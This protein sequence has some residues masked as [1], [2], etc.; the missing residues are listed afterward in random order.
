MGEDAVASIVKARQEGEFKDLY[1]FCNRVDT[2][3]VGKRA[4]EALVCAGCFDDM[5]LKLAPQFSH[6]R[7][8]VRGG[9][10]EQLP[11][12][13]EVA[14]QNRQNTIDGTL[15]LFAEVDDG[16]SVAPPLP[17]IVWGDQTRLRG[18]K[19][20]LGLYLTGHPLD[21]YRQEL[22]KFVNVTSLSDVSDTGAGKFVRVAGLIVDVAN[23]GNRIA[24]TLDDGTAR[25]EISCYTDK[26]TQ[27]KPVLE[28]SISLSDAL[29][30]KYERT[31]KT[32]KNF[33]PQ[34]LNVQTLGRVDKKDWENIHNLNG[35]III[36]RIS[37]RE[38]DGRLFCR[39]HGAYTLPQ[40]RLRHLSGVNLKLAS[41]DLATLS[42]LI[43]L[44]KENAPPSAQDIP[45]S[46]DDS[47][48]SDGCLPI[49]LYIYDDCGLCK[50]M[51]NE[52][53]RFY[54]SDEAMDKLGQLFEP[55][56]FKVY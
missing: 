38:N 19:D 51:V 56:A 35:A 16:L 2:K 37:V 43:P 11:S 6:Q 33:N 25:L 48:Q 45:P 39:L 4:L 27:L 24:I 12:A 29:M 8:H 54:P 53:F 41:D 21:K 23:F 10:W 26:Y 1:D 32:E 31:I 34:K 42:Q 47:P 17:N 5:A 7:H 40:A 22:P 9:L 52:R 46:D 30:V 28:S 44:L 50:V 14:H 20:T 49:S 3:K 15:D 36:A 18:E 13:M 55:D